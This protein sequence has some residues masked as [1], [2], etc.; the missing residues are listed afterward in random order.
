[1]ISSAFGKITN[2]HG[3]IVAEGAVEVDEERAAVTLRPILDMP[4][5]ERQRGLLRLTLDDGQELSERLYSE[6]PDLAV[7]Y[8]SGHTGDELA[9]RRRLDASVPFLQKPFP[10]D[11]LVERVQELLE[12]RAQ[13]SDA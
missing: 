9:R 5:L 1:M 2:E 13:G 12:R 7:L 4:L 10:P 8:I 3:E 6:R 11:E